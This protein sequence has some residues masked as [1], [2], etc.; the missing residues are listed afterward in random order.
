MILR[1]T[2]VLLLAAP[3]ALLTT[4]AGPAAAG[5]SKSDKALLKAGTLTESDVPDDWTSKKASSSD[6]SRSIRECRQ[7][8]AAVD[9]AKKKVPRVRS[10]KFQEPG[11][12]ATAAQDTVYAFK[13]ATAASEFLANF[14]GDGAAACLQK[15]AARQTS[16][17]GGA[18]PIIYPITN[19]EG[20]GDAAV[21]WEITIDFTTESE[22]V[23]LYIDFVAV[24]VGRAFVGFAFSS[25]NESLPGGL[26]IIETVV[27]RVAQAQAST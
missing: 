20:V 14:Q 16:E 3:L 10:R 8:V 18:D 13:D 25:R 9:N 19:L 21:G 17:E 1:H 6:P 15:N 27:D 2:R 26:S 4:L 11:D 22:R 23:T 24:Q 5:E 7:I 12:E